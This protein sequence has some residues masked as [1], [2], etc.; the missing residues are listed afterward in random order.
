ML[1]VSPQLG[2]GFPDAEALYDRSPA[3][4]ISD[5]LWRDRYAADPAIV[6]RPVRLN[7]RAHVVLG[8]MPPGFHFPDDVDVWQRLTWDLRLH[9]RQA[10]FMEAVARL[11]DQTTLAQA[12]AAVDAL[13]TRLE[14]DYGETQNSPGRGWGRA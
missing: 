3:I 8:V 4:V 1:G 6:G 12:Q 9:S 5:R 13:W 11:S 2:A 7:G 14:A 10:H